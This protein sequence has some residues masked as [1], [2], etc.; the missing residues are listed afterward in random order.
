[1]DCTCGERR[2]SRRSGPRATTTRTLDTLIAAG[3]DIFRL[4]FS[5][6]TARDRRPRRST[7]SAPRPR[8]PDAT[9]RFFRISAGRRSEPGTLEGGR[10]RLLCKG[11]HAR[12]RDRRRSPASRAGSRRRSTAWRAASSRA[13][14]CC[15]PT[16]SIELRVDS[17]DGSDDPDDGRRRRRAR[18]AQGHQRAR[19]RA[20][21]VGDHARRTSRICA[22]ACRSA[23]T[24]SR[25]ASCRRAADLHEA[26]QL[27][28][29]ANARRRAAR[30]EAR[31]S[32]GARASRRD[33]G[34]VRRRDGGARRSRPRDAARARADGPEGHHAARAPRTAS[35]SSWRRRCSSR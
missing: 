13:I 15:S 16:G 12:D 24:W 9:S 4:N 19:R 22:R 2:S 25:S 5:H 32:A 33:P 23:S 35:R 18:R 31:A 28:T 20:A 30:R 21:G 1:M 14:G 26:R 6:G 27:L 10:R 11:E 3:A 7:A 8:A 34:V 17:T 29:A